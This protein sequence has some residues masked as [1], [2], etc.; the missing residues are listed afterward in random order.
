MPPSLF[1][2]TDRVRVVRLEGDD[3]DVD[4]AVDPPQQPRIGDI[5]TVIEE[6]A[7]GIYLVERSTDDGR[8]LWIAEFL[9]S[10][11]DLVERQ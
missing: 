9:A 1:L 7:E 6:V 8:S 10:E 4:S 3:R 5:G 11:L 2:P